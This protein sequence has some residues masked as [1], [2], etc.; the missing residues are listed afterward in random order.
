M[1]S[2]REFAARRDRPCAVVAHRGAWRDAPENSIAAVEA[3]ADAG[4]EVVEVDVRKSADGILFVLHDDNLTRMAGRDAAGESLAL[5][6]LAQTRL[7]NRDGQGE[8]TSQTVPS[9]AA[10]FGHA[11][12]RVYVNLDLKDSTLVREVQACAVAEGVADQVD[13]KANLTAAG[14]IAPLR[15]AGWLD[16]VA[17]TPMARFERDTADDVFRAVAEIAPAVC[18]C[19]FDDVATLAGLAGRFRE[20]G[21]AMWANTLEDSML[22]DAHALAD[23]DAVWGRLIDAGVSVIQTDEPEALRAYLAR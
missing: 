16:G 6:E 12:D 7:R 14:D 20:A 2:Y 11:R 15:D 17:F 5:A 21:I 18:E 3:A 13:I 4:Y 9:L 23:P 22:H 10:V 19:S 8:L 1:Q